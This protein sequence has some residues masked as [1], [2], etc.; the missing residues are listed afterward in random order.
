MAEML[1]CLV[2]YYSATAHRDGMPLQYLCYRIVGGPGPTAEGGVAVIT[3][4]GAKN[5]GESDLYHHLHAVQA[6]GPRAALTAALNYLD[7]VHQKDDLARAQTEIRCTP[8]VQASRDELADMPL[9]LPRWRP[10]HAPIARP[11]DDGITV[12]D[13]HKKPAH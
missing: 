10:Q 1:D 2:S 4:I 3:L 5:P 7:A 11:S 9:D 12:L 6:G 8:C 13:A